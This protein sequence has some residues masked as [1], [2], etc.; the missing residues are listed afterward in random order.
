MRVGWITPR[1]RPF[2]DRCTR[3]RLDARGRVLRCLMDPVRF[4]LAGLLETTCESHV[5][6]GLHAYVSG[7][8]VSSA[9]D[10][11][12]PMVSVGG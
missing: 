3:L 4:D 8:V 6:R 1:S 2:C 10:S 12:L 5:R 7:K 11:S 9:M